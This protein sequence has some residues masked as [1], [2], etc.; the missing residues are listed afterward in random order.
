[1]KNSKE[2]GLFAKII[3]HSPFVIMAKDAGFDFIFYDTEHSFYSFEMLHD[4]M[5]FGN[6]IGMKSFVR[7]RRND[8]GNLSVLLDCGA[9]GIM[10]PMVETEE[11]AKELVEYTK[12]PPIGKRSYSSGAN[13]FYRRF[14]GHRT[15]MDTAN[16]EIFTIAQIESKKGIENA[17]KIAAISGID[18]LLLGPVDLSV[19]LGLE[20]NFTHPLMLENID[21]LVDACKTH[22][23][24]MGIIGQTVL[25]EKYY[26]NL[27]IIVNSIDANIIRD[28]FVNSR[29]DTENIGTDKTD[30][31]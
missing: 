20:N 7:A 14:G 24:K 15:A 28:G 10:L 22:K 27:D 9:K 23:K 5:L 16:K 2:Y 11:E 12:Y 18:C 29:I 3:T 8:R 6:A 21:K 25:I 26:E 4:L 13:T 31:K 19:S 30:T 1:M 17:H